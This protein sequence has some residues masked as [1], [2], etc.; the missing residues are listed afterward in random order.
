MVLAHAFGRARKLPPLHEGECMCIHC[1]PCLRHW[2]MHLTRETRSHLQGNSK[3]PWLPNEDAIL[4]FNFSRA[5][6]NPAPPFSNCS[7][8]LARQHDSLFS[9]CKKVHAFAKRNLPIGSYRQYSDHV[10]VLS[11]YCIAWNS[12]CMLVWILSIGVQS[13]LCVGRPTGHKFSIPRQQ[14]YSMWKRQKAS[15][16]GLVRSE[17][18]EN[19]IKVSHWLCTYWRPDNAGLI[20][21]LAAGAAIAFQAA[22]SRSPIATECS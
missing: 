7:S 19:W 4:H 9:G 15:S 5:L 16:F 13:V 3:T 17:K 22:K 18:L 1:S 11:L 14:L 12:E 10:L 20:L 8:A 2:T 21:H 6:R